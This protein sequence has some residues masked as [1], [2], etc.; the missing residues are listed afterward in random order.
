MSCAFEGQAAK[1]ALPPTQAANERAPSE[2]SSETS[3]SED[4]RRIHHQRSPPQRA[5]LRLSTYFLYERFGRVKIYSG[6]FWYGY[7]FSCL[8]MTDFFRGSFFF[9]EGSEAPY[10]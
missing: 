2:R 10:V 1:P 8:G 4:E 5:V 3:G 6:S 7:N 9:I